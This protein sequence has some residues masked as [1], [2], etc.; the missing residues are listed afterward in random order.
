MDFQ[1]AMK[2]GLKHPFNQEKSAAGKK[3]FR[4]FLKRQL[5]L[6]RRTSEGISAARVKDFISENVARVLKPMKLNQE[7]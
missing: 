6:P 3:Y 4:S 7:W 2:I 5:V 1:S